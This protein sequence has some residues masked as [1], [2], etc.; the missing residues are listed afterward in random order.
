M[1]SCGTW[2]SWG[3]SL[4]NNNF[5][6]A[7]SHRRALGH[8]LQL[9]SV[10][11]LL[12]GRACSEHLFV[13]SLLLLPACTQPQQWQ[14]CNFCYILA[15]V[16]GLAW[17]ER[18]FLT[19]SICSYL[20]QSP[21]LVPL[22]WFTLYPISSP[23]APLRKRLSLGQ[24]LHLPNALSQCCNVCPGSLAHVKTASS[25]APPAVLTIPV[26]LAL[27][28]CVNVVPLYSSALCPGKLCT[29]SGTSM[30]PSCSLPSADNK[31]APTCF[32]S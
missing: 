27:H 21:E 18:C 20:S 13:L 22:L 30:G 28:H 17:T 11:R 2:K 6:I 10:R 1:P 15:L 9:L 12:L 31:E 16:W 19:F 24:R 26:I 23:S 32:C 25:Q 8:Y 3:S 5:M 14:E 29:G 4:N 7:K